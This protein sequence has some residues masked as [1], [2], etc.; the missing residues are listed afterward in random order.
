MLQT[1]KKIRPSA[2]AFFE[3]KE[4]VDHLYVARE[5]DI[6]YLLWLGKENGS[7]ERKSVLFIQIY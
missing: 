3:E 7:C 6:Y 1:R 5:G 2:R 4:D